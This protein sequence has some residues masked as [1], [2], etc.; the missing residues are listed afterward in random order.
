MCNQLKVEFFKFRHFW[1]FYIAV[2]CMAGLGFS[3]GYI[4]L[5]SMGYDLYDAFR[6]TSCD[7][8]FMIILALVSAWFIGSDFSNRTIHHEITLGYSRW[9]VLMVR[10]LPVLLSGI[11]LHFIYVISCMLGVGSK[12]GFSVS[13][14][15]VQDLFWCIT[16]MLQLMALQSIVL[17]ISFICAN[18]PAAIAI[19]VSIMVIACNVLRNFLKGTFFTK[20]VFYFAPNNTKETLL[21][22]SAVAV[23][24]LVIIMVSTYI[25][26]R[27]KEIK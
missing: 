1:L 5:A 11:L 23:M 22:T 7:T 14:F 27:K 13:M 8:S 18:A 4:K 17:F 26:F 24:T 9:S 12:T 2:I 16:I 25:V 21:P 15:S 19:S 3:Y 6:E 10:E 20:S